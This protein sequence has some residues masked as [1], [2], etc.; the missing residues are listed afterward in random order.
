MEYQLLYRNLSKFYD[1]VYGS[2]NYEKEV[3]KI[4][5]L[6]EKYKKSKGNSLLDV[7]CGTGK[8]IEYLRGKYSIFGVDINKEILDIAKEKFKDITFEQA[9]MISLNINIKF[10]IILCMFSSIAYVKSK[11]NLE[12]TIINFYNHV[13]IGGVIIID[14][15]LT[16]STYKVG[17]TFMTTF[18]SSDIKIARLSISKIEDNVSITDMSYLVAEKNNEI[19]YFSDRHELGLFEIDET[20]AIM[21]KAGFTAKYLKNGLLKE[22]GLYL[23][24]KD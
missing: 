5:T 17:S 3:I 21:K 18:E 9:D 7:G 4:N 12:K 19:K 13:K 10:D 1:F 20:L 6:I 11:E 15:W 22:R 23:G 2:K 24:I 14:P 16:K 8:H